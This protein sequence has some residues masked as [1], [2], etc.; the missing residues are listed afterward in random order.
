MKRHAA[1]QALSREHHAALVLALACKRAAESGSE[2]SIRETCTK[3]R[4]L[5]AA[6][7][8]PHFH[9]E[10]E[11]LLPLLDRAGQTGLVRRTL[12]EHAQLRALVAALST[13]QSAGLEAFGQ[14]LSA[15]VRFEEHELF[16]GA[17]QAV[18]EEQLGI[19]FGA[20]PRLDAGQ[21]RKPK[22]A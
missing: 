3:V 17:E 10:E 4:H 8:E 15:H 1:L 21:G 22:N 19:A 16:P 7:L 12:A 2:A 20:P 14:A 6:E 11:T 5:F 9:T 13:P 18:P